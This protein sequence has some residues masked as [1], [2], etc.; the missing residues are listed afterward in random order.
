M[1]ADENVAIVRRGYEA[2]NT[3]DIETL[4]EVFDESIV[5][6]L[7]GRSSMAKDYHGRDATLAYF[8]QIG[9]ETGGTFQ[10]ELQQL[11]AGD[12]GRVI[13]LQRST[14]ERNGKRLDV[15]NCIVF[16]LNDGKVVDGREHFNDLYAWDEFWS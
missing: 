9:Q 15:G 14:A 1:G 12:D 16:E 5:W 8:G 3:G 7:P 13:G 2:F 4:T 11:F 6:H 10:A